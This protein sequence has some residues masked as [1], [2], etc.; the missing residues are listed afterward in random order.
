VN[1]SAQLYFGRT[2]LAA[3]AV[4][5]NGQSHGA[6]SRVA[7]ARVGSRLR[8]PHAEEEHSVVESMMRRTDHRRALGWLRRSHAAPHDHE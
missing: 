5:S 8:S 4:Y 1:S 3:Y 2:R 7:T 6:F